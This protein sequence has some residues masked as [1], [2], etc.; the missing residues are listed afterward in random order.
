M[1]YGR[2]WARNECWRISRPLTENEAEKWSHK[3]QIRALSKGIP[4]AALIILHGPNKLDSSLLNDLMAGFIIRQGCTV[5][6]LNDEYLVH[7][8]SSESVSKSKDMI[9]SKRTV[10]EIENVELDDFVFNMDEEY[11]N[12]ARIIYGQCS[13]FHALGVSPPTGILISGPPG[14]GKFTM[15]MNATKRFKSPTVIKRLTSLH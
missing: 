13:S 3:V 11:W 10:I 1:F 6:I 2:A 9:I 15:A 12:I 14:V 4:N 7:S 8:C 5:N